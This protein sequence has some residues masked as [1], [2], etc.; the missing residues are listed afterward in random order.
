M[1]RVQAFVIGIFL[2]CAAAISAEPARDVVALTNAFRQEKGQ[3]AL[4][5]STKLE[6]IA[7][8]HGNDMRK[9]DFFSHTGSDGSD[10]ALRAKRHGYTYC[11]LAENIAFG[12]PTAE[13]VTDGW[14]KSRGHRKNMLNRRVTEIGVIKEG[15]YWV[16]VLAQ[17]C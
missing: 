10:I 12:Q 16:M 15:K 6:A 1:R 13:R 8:S 4:V 17:P 5:I 2:T 7:Q 9:N 14:S 3:P 11:V